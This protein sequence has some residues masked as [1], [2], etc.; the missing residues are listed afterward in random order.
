MPYIFN[1]S[2][3]IPL[4]ELIWANESLQAITNTIPYANVGASKAGFELLAERLAGNTSLKRLIPPLNYSPNETYAELFKILVCQT[5]LTFLY[6]PPDTL[7]EE[8]RQEIQHLLSM[9][10]EQREI[11]IFSNA[12]S[13]AKSNKW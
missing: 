2:C 12:K 9:P 13:A 11:P 4:C 7:T 10:V 3:I 1:D 5:G 8:E 6:I